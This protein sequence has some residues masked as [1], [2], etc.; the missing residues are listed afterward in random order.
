MKLIFVII[1]SVLFGYNFSDNSNST[2][3][4]DTVKVKHKKEISINKHNNSN[5]NKRVNERM[6]FNSPFYNSERKIIVQLKSGDSGYNGSNQNPTLYNTFGKYPIT[7]NQA[8]G[9]GN[10][11]ADILT[12]GDKSITSMDGYN[13][14]ME[15][16]Y[17]KIQDADETGVD[18][19]GTDCKLCEEY[20]QYYNS[21]Y[22][23]NGVKDDININDSGNVRAEYKNVDLGNYKLV[24][25][26]KYFIIRSAQE[27]KSVFLNCDS[28]KNIDFD[29]YVLIGVDQPT[30]GSEKISTEVLAITKEKTILVNINVV[31]YSI[32]KNI[33]GRY[34]KW[35]LINKPDNNWEIK[36]LNNE[37]HL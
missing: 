18:C 4:T 33:W 16:C 21:S 25:N 31:F 23:T 12:D 17:N 20:Q 27:A 14:S 30:N 9:E 5:Q 8:T 36:V 35:L 10:T 32:N 13:A 22:C 24:I 15:H 6:L 7:W 37:K 28:I 3:I 26:K 2:N 29:K 11:L 1:I 19:G 34:K